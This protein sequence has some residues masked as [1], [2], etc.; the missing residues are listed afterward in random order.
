[1]V[2]P[3]LQSL[4]QYLLLKNTN[5]TDL[6]NPDGYEAT[7]DT[8]TKNLED[9]FP[10][11][12]TE[13]EKSRG[14]AT[15]IPFTYG[16]ANF[17]GDKIIKNTGFM[18]GAIGGALAQD[19]IIGFATE[20]VGALPLVAAQIGKASLYLNKIFSGANKVDRVLDLAKT[21]G[22]SGQTLLNIERLGQLAAAQKVSNGFRIWN[23]CIWI[24]KNRSCY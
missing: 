19:A 6:S 12:V 24:C 7:V 17:W 10:N 9:Y 23:V 2:N 5:V 13:Y 16:S 22:K 3:L 1:L 20:G 8:W 21:A 11:Y 14:L 18:V 15:A 4:I